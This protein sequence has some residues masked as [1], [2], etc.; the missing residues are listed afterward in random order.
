MLEERP[1]SFGE[2]V[3]P[4]A[5][6]AA[7]SRLR[8]RRANAAAGVPVETKRGLGCRLVIGEDP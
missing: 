4:N 5:L 6:E 2:A 3:T 1:Y 7:V 8:K